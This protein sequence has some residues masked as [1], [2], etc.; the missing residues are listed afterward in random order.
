MW[1]VVAQCGGSAT[2]V[3]GGSPGGCKLQAWWSLKHVKATVTLQSHA[4]YQAVVQN[5]ESLQN[6]LRWQPRPHLHTVVY[7]QSI[8]PAQARVWGLARCG[9]HDF[10]DG[11]SARHRGEN[12]QRPCRFCASAT[13]SLQHALLEC[14]AHN[15]ARQRWRRHMRNALSLDTL[16][17]TEPHV[18]ATR[19][20]ARNVAFVAHVCLAAAA[21]EM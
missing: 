16:F 8:D 3:C 15:Q 1:R 21:C 11:R 20:I 4:R 19:S 10:S 18:N 12:P 13:D 9:H 6:Y 2:R 14:T 5:T 7:G 17:S